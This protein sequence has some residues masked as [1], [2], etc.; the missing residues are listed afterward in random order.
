MSEELKPCDCGSRPELYNHNRKEY[1]Y[2]CYGC[3]VRGKRFKTEQEAVEAWNQR[4][5]VKNE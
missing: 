3:D 5:E 4:H 2:C 1:F